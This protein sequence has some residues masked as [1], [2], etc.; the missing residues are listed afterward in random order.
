MTVRTLPVRS[1]AGSPTGRLDFLDGLRGIAVA[2]VLLQH[3]GELT[4]PAIERL[5]SSTVQ[6]GQFGVMVASAPPGIVARPLE[7]VVGKTKTV[8]L[9]YDVLLAARALGVTFGD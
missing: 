2:L 4:V 8:P 9:D 6:L 7:D 5:T 1:R 3:I